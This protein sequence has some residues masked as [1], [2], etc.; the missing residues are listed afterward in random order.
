MLRS[1]GLF[2]TNLQPQDGMNYEIGLRGNILNSKLYFDI[3]AFLFHLKNTI[4]QRI[5]AAGVFY[6]VNAGSTRQKGAESLISYDLLSNPLH[7]VSSAKLWI[8]YAN[9]DFRYKSFKQVSTDFSGKK[10]PGVPKQTIWAGL[11]ISSKPGLYLNMTY[12]Y[13]DPV[14]LNDA[15][16]AYA[17][18]YNLLG[19]RI[20][21]RKNFNGKLRGEIFTGGENLFDTRYSLGND[22]NAAAGRYFNAA[23]GRNFYAGVSVQL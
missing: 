17:S 11:D 5:D 14:A 19:A 1:D 9:H 20:G 10:L 22:I 3:N 16:G 7:V 18:S 12:T 6:Y 4:V 8:S 21:F 15:N 2:G 23:P 13:S